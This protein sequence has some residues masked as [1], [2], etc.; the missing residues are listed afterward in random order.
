MLID[1]GDEIKPST[2]GE[3]ARIIPRRLSHVNHCF[4]YVRDSFLPDSWQDVS[5]A[6]GAG[7]GGGGGLLRHR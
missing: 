2:S 7:F 4:V 3:A 5:L 1:I 6:S